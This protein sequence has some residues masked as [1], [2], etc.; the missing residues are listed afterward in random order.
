MSEVH[1]LLRHLIPNAV[2]D[3]VL[4]DWCLLAEWT[5][6]ILFT[7]LALSQLLHDILFCTVS[8][9]P[10]PV[11]AVKCLQL[12]DLESIHTNSTL[13]SSIISLTL[14]FQSL[15]LLLSFD[16]LSGQLFLNIVYLIFADELA[17]VLKSNG[18]AADGA[19]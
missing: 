15:K 5:G 7:V 4:V 10:V 18:S 13:F 2:S 1:Q 14:P 16:L 9:Y 17:E 8:A 11:I 6:H 3:S 12:V 19:A